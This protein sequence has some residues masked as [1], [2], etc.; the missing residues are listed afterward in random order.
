MAD[1]SR[2]GQL[3]TSAPLDLEIYADVKTGFQLPEAGRYT[4]RAPESFPDTA[5]GATKAGFLSAQID[6]TI[7]GPTNEG[8]QIRF[9]KVSA[10]TYKR[11]GADVSQLGD[12]LRAC[13]MRVQV[14]GDPQSLADAVERTANAV[15]Q[16]DVDWRAY[17]KNT[18][19]TVEGMKNF[20]PRRDKDG[21]V[22][23]GYQSWVEDPTEKGED[24][25][26]LRLRA[27]LQVDR[28]IPA[29]A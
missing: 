29:G 16:V 15:Y 25:K 12:Y 3:N 7:V 22:I 10:K 2:L 11:S 26:P 6:P 21:N 19:F 23:G 18:G 5:F 24:G 28:Y 27:N 9:T 4:V 13:G 20:P 14:T 1:I 8:F 17:N